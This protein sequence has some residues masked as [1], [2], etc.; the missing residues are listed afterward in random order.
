MNGRGLGGEVAAPDRGVLTFDSRED[1]LARRDEVVALV[2][3]WMRAT[4][5]G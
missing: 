1:L 5:D 3:A 2:N 4:R